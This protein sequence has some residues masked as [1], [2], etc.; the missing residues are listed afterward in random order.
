M[1]ATDQAELCAYCG[2]RPGTTDDHVVARNLFLPPRPDDMVT[3]PACDDCNGRKS[4]CDQYL[5]DMLVADIETYNHPR[6]RRLLDGKAM[7][8]FRSNRS[9]LAQ[10]ARTRA[11]YVPMHSPGGIYLGHAPSIPLEENIVNEAFQFIARGLHFKLTGK[12]MPADA[13]FEVS[14]VKSDQV[15]PAVTDLMS[16]GANG[17]YRIGEDFVCLQMHAGDDRGNSFWMLG[18]FDTIFIT[19][20]AG[21]I[22]ADLKE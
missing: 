6:A 22:P 8:A 21:D 4:M 13:Q 15:Q 16:R 5:R 3:V 1:K 18:F 7:R 19:V 2:I 14:R 17:P 20:A 10:A 9:R 11:R 12:R